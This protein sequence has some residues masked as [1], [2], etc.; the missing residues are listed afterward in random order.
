MIKTGD[1]LLCTGGNDCYVEGNTYTVGEFVNGKYFELMTGCNDEHWY[2]TI[3]D[4]GIHVHF[5][6]LKDDSSDAWFN[7]VEQKN[8]A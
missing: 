1:K 7:E 3:D 8:C 5:N 2:A 4:E 6:S